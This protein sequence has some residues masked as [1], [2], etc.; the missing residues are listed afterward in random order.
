[1]TEAER[2]QFE[3]EIEHGGRYRNA[4]ELVNR[5][6]EEKEASLYEAF[7][8]APSSDK[9]LLVDI[10]MQFNAVEGLKQEF[11]THITTADMAA[12]SISEEVKKNVEK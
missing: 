11:M 5:F 8:G 7:K 1:M 6:I 4:W 12:K 9:D 3:N 10:R 2:I